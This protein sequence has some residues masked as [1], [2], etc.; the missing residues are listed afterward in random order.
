MRVITSIQEARALLTR[1]HG[2]HVLRDPA[3]ATAV[4]AIIEGVRTRGDE[5]VREYTAQFDG[6]APESL[7]VSQPEQHSALERLPRELTMA[8]RAAA[9][10]IASFHEASLP[11]GWFDESRG[12]GER[13]VP[14]QRVG[15]YVPGGTAA[16]PSSLLMDVIPARIAGV[17]EVIV[18]TPR[19]GDVTLGAAAL[20]GVDRLFAIGGAQAIAAMAYGTQSIPAVDKVCGAGSIHVTEAKRALFGVVAIDGLYGPTETLVIA[21]DSADASLAAADLLAQAEH[22]ALASPLLIATSESVARDIVSAVATQ[23]DG[24]ERAGIAR[25][26]LEGQGLAVVASSVE[27]AIDLANDYAPEHVCLLV[28]DA[29]R[30]AEGIRHAGGV[31]AGEH[32]PEVLGDYVAGPSHTMPTM[33]AARASSYLGVHHFIRHMPIVA[34]SQDDVLSLG[35]YAAAIARA[36]GLTAHAKAVEARLEGQGAPPT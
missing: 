19:P 29:A 23:L 8:L 7:E 20:A 18:C 31:F 33:G 30:Y 32:S 27:E 22:D 17:D 35:P 34:L 12:L 26:A 16:Y 15:I 13:V 28:R 10:R 11:K 14:L 21:D 24:L 3:L 36:E 25:Q 5:A 1:R 2:A 4:A 9:D 6:A